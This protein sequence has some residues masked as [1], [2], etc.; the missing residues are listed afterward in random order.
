MLEQ[1]MISTLAIVDAL[2]ELLIDQ[3]VIAEAEFKQKVLKERAMDQT[4]LQ[5][6][7]PH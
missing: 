7:K 5:N 4:L 1:L 2:T 3:G 6:A